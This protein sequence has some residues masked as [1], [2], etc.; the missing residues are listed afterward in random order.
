MGKGAGSSVSGGSGKS[1][2][3]GVNHAK[4]AANVDKAMADHHAMQAR[5]KKC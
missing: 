2:N 3:Q 1:A 4:T 5:D